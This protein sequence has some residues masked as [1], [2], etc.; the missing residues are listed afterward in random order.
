[1][2]VGTGIFLSSVLLAIVILYGVA[3]DRWRWRRIVKLFSCD[4]CA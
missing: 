4:F 2:S 1:M 3:K